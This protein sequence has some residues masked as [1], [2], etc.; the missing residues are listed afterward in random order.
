MQSEKWLLCSGVGTF[1]G[2]GGFK[3]V[4]SCPSFFECTPSFFECTFLECT[5]S[6]VLF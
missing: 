3:L 1:F 4:K 6:N 5:F 2:Q